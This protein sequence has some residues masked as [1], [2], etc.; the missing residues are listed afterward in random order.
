VNVRVGFPQGLLTE[1]YPPVE[2]MKPAFN[3]FN[4][5]QPLS[6]SLLDWGKVWIIP[7]NRL[8]VH[9]A[10]SQLAQRLQARAIQRLLPASNDHPHYAHARETDSALVYVERPGDEKRPVAPKG[11][12]FEKFLFYRGV[13]NFELPLKVAALPGERFEVHNTGTDPIRSLFLVTVEGKQL[14]FARAAAVEAGQMLSL[15]QSQTTSSSDELAEKVV[16]ALVA[17]KLY[18]KEARA[19]V[20]TWRSS[21]FGEDGTRLFYLLP[22]PITDAL[23]PL[24]IDPVP[25]D[26]VRV[27]VGRLEIM[28]PEDESRVTTLVKQSAQDRAAAGEKCAENPQSKPYVIPDAIL[29]LG[30]LAEPALV[31]VKA[32]A[33]DAG[34]GREATLLLQQ[35]HERRN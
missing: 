25:D 18:E 13:G 31:R 34:T 4:E 27:M 28:R 29:Q 24:E 3:W 20:N 15:T 23:L 19:M 7:E 16:A 26:V 2:Q 8:Q 21:W 32:I 12:F 1:F 5:S 6:D 30:R 33:S 14:R 9:V 35:L 10:D 22:R 17:E 11:L